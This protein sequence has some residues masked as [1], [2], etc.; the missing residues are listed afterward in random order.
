MAD[1]LSG[2][3]ADDTEAETFGNWVGF[4]PDFKQNNQRQSVR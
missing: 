2:L 1:V 3:P 4:P